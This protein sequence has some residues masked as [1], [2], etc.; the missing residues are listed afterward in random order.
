MQRS[1]ALNPEQTI[2]ILPVATIAQHGPLP[3]RAIG[4]SNEYLLS[5]P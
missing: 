3:I 1:P 5:P 4:K 2:V